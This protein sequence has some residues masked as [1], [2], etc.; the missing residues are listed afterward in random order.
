MDEGRWIKP[1]EVEKR[2]IL[3]PFAAN[4]NDILHQSFFL[5]KGFMGEFARK[6]I[7]SLVDSLKNG[8][9]FHEWNQEDARSFIEGLDEKLIRKLLMDLYKQCYEADIN[10]R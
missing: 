8:N 6:K 3:N 2:G 4:V 5:D 10:R 7:L 9:N 1:A